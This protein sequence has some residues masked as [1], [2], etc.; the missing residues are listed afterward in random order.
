MYLCSKDKRVEYEEKSISKGTRLKME[1]ES[2]VKPVKQINT[3]N[4]NEYSRYGMQYYK[5]IEKNDKNEKLEVFKMR[6]NAFNKVKTL[7][8][9]KALLNKSMPVQLERTVFFIGDAKCTIINRTDQ[10]RICLKTATEII[11]YDF[12]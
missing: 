9:A 8:E 5:P 4:L 6:L 1:Q 7:E 2:Q 11:G 3:A 12:R 10:L